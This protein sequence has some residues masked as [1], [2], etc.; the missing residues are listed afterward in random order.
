MDN[1][2]VRVTVLGDCGVEHSSVEEWQQCKLCERM[3]RAKQFLSWQ[4]FNDLHNF[5]NV[6]RPW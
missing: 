2:E 4:L 6:P 1:L 5:M 3:A